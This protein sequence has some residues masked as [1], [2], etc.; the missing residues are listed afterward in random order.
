MEVQQAEGV[1]IGKRIWKQAFVLII[2][3]LPDLRHLCGLE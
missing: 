1:G 2:K 3:P